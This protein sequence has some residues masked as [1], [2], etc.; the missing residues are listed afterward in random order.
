[1]TSSERNLFR[2]VRDTR[3]DLLHSAIKNIVLRLQHVVHNAEEHIEHS[4][5]YIKYL[6]E[7]L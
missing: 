2:Y 4:L 5:Q 1:M 6:S 3:P 7:S